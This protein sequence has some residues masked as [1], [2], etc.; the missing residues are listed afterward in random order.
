LA[1]SSISIC[2]I[3][4]ARTPRPK[5]GLFSLGPAQHDNRSKMGSWIGSKKFWKNR[6]R[7]WQ[8]L[9]LCLWARNKT[10]IDRV[11]LRRRTKS[12][13]S[14]SW[15]KYFEA[16]AHLILRFCHVLTDPLKQLRTVNS[17]WYTTICLP[18]VFGDSR[19]NE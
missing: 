1:I 8:N 15:K 4:I 19:K 11:G 18:K 12:N 14:F 10:A 2:T 5:K 16:N 13:E 6:S 9:D 17:E 7:R 3:D